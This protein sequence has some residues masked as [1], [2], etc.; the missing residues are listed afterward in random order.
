MHPGPPLPRLFW[1][2]AWVS[3]GALILLFI[4]LA[5][6]GIESLTTETHHVENWCRTVGIHGF[7]DQVY[8]SVFGLF[9]N[10]FRKP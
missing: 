2:T 1:T 9:S 4:P 3:L 7:L 5:L 10:R 6:A 8:E